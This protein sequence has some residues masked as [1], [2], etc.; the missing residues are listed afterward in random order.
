MEVV[1]DLFSNLLNISDTA[2]TRVVYSV[3]IVI[4]L[5]LF[6]FIILF[7]AFRNTSDPKSRF[8]WRRTTTY[9]ATL[10]GFLL[11]GR[12]WF[13][14]MQSLATFLGLLSAGLA[15]ALRELISNFAG[16]VFILWRQPFH[17]G[18]RIQIGDQHGDVI[19][20]RVLMFSL[21]EIGNWVDADQST[22][23][24]LHI[25]NSHIFTQ[26]LANYT[27][28]F[29][30]IWHEIPVHITFGSNAEKAR[31]ILQAIAEKHSAGCAEEA[32]IQLKKASDSV[33]I[34]YKVLTPTVYLSVRENGVRLTVRYLT[35]PRKRRGTEQSIWEDTLRAFK[36]DPEI[37]FAY[38]TIRI[39][40]HDKEGK[41]ARRKQE[42]E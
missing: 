2:A 38:Q 42:D 6:R 40:D 23:R 29:R 10:I 18:D 25:P 26:V 33:L 4:L 9:V 16:W 41:K 19:D 24:V 8:K 31:H 15:I 34:R 36:E 11:I 39:Y 35:D 3:S 20:K 32:G 28:E 13:E 17:L 22:G 5:V 7:I 21:I 14:G 37:E 1:T 27:S 12:E 30:F